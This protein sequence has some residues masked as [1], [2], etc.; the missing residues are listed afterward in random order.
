[1]DKLQ[2]I[3]FVFSLYAQKPNHNGYCFNYCMKR[4]QLDKEL[5]REQ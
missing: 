4:E 3:E 5:S 1:M 2:P